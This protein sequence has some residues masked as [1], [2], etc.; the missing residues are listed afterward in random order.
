MQVFFRYFFGYVSIKIGGN[1][2]ERFLNVCAANRIKLWDY[3]KKGKFIYAKILNRDYLKLRPLRRRCEVSIKI[4]SKHGLPKKTKPYKKRYG[5]VAGVALYTLIMTFLT[6]I[7]WNIE[8]KGNK[9]ISNETI[10]KNCK[11]IGISEG[12]FKGGIN[13]EDARLKLILNNGDISWASFIIEGS[14]LTVNISE[15]LKAEK[16]DTSPS[17]LVAT[18]DGVV[19]RIEIKRGMPAVRVNQAVLKGELLATGAMRYT[20]GTTHFVNSSGKVIAKTKRSH[21]VIVNSVVAEKDYSGN[22]EIRR[23]LKFFGIS[24]PLSYTPIAEPTDKTTEEIKL[25]CNSSY[26][27]VYVVKT[28]FKPY[29]IKNVKLNKKEMLKRAQAELTKY[30]ENEMADC[31]ILSYN[32]VV[33]V[34]DKG[35]VVT[36]QYECRENIAKVEKI[37]IN[38]VN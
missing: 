9:T 7:I 11:S 21:T 8:I 30:Q 22:K 29:K 4:V 14:H 10:L 27:P 24:I 32:D 19:E 23:V 17:N 25:M 36:R 33:D 12:V 18:I 6:S 31:E 1:F 16:T 3:D 26:V 34:T 28:T 2:P 5:I 37:K 20:D 13:T 15:T 35:I 38:T